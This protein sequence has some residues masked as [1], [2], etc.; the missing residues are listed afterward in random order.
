METY[1]LPCAAQSVGP[2]NQ[3][4]GL[5]INTLLASQCALSPPEMWPKDY[6]PTALEKGFEEYDFIVVGAGS[7]GSVVANRLSENPNWKVLLLEAGGDPPIESEIPNMPLALFRTRVDWQYYTEKSNTGLGYKNSHYWPRGKLL[8]GSGSINANLYIRGN[9]RDYDTWEELGNVG[10]NWQDVIRYFKRSEDNKIEHLFELTGS[11]YHAKGGPMKIDYFY[12]VEMMKIAVE[13][14]A[15]ELGEVEHMDINADQHIGWANVFGNLDNGRRCSPAKGFLIQ[16][17][18]RTNLHIVKNA[19][20]TKVNV[21]EKNEVEGVE[22]SLKDKK[23]NVKSTR[24]TIMSAGTVNTPQLLMLS[25]IGPKAHLD[26]MKIPVKKDLAVGKNLQDHFAIPIYIGFHKNRNATTTIQ[27]MSD[28]VYS[29]VMHNK[30]SLSGVGML[31][32]VGFYNTLNN[33]LPYPDIQ[34]HTLYFRRIAPQ[35]KGYLKAMQFTPE[36]EKY[37]E[38]AHEKYDILCLMVTLLK[39]DVPGKIE[40]RSTD[41]FDH[42]KI[43]PNYMA[44]KSELETA[45]RGIRRI[46]EYMKTESYKMHDPDLFKIDLK[47]C[48]L[49][50]FDSDEY[51]ECYIRHMGTTIYH[52]V[53]TSKMGPKSDPDAVVSDELKVNGVKGLRVVDASIMPVIISANTNAAAVM[54]GEKGADMIKNEWKKFDKKDEDDVSKKDSKDDKVGEEL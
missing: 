42:P 41:P 12:S 35:M 25:G 52:P 8:G 47:N 20:V 11:Q 5:L 31:N 21:N 9:K 2:A 50:D 40:L 32:L 54:I 33:S 19:H 43:F 26:E 13:E 6:G 45:I 1:T 30:G 36:V 28:M 22:L 49:L 18:N 51:W 4:I 37:M 46:Q 10:W 14:G 15:F 53:G 27:D 34:F 7:A 17:A 24:E 16:A 39:Q 48:E 44:G 38:K 23:F 3:L 29:Y